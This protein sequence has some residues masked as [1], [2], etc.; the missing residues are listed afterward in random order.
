MIHIKLYCIV[1]SLI[2]PDPALYDVPEPK[3]ATEQRG[4][5]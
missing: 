4:S 3:F 5:N 2:V 1:S